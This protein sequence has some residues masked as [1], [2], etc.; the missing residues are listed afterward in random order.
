MLTKELNGAIK[1]YALK[2]D[3]FCML[4]G[5]TGERQSFETILKI[6]EGLEVKYDEDCISN[7]E[8]FE[9]LQQKELLDEFLS[10]KGQSSKVVTNKKSQNFILMK[11]EETLPQRGKLMD[12]VNEFDEEK[13]QETL[14]AVNRAMIALE[15]S[16]HE[17]KMKSMLKKEMGQICLILKRS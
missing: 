17:D 10:G 1:P 4:A 6:D 3:N 13:L 15:D 11:N 9:L 8:I 14:T 5:F 12:L 7:E 2:I 16:L